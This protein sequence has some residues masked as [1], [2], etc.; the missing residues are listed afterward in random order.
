LSG[1]GPDPALLAEDDEEED[2]FV[3]LVSVV[4]VAAGSS[5]VVGEEADVSAPV[6]V[7]DVPLEVAPVDPALV[8]SLPVVVVVD[9]WLLMLELLVEPDLLDG[10]A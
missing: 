9:F 8:S 2:F 7:A 5:L 10:E 1:E 4:V 3:L 6:S